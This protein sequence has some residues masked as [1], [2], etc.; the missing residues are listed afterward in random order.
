MIDFQYL[1]EILYTK[2]DSFYKKNVAE[3]GH[4][5][6]RIKFFNSFSKQE[7]IFHIIVLVVIDLS[8]LLQNF[9]NV[10]V[11]CVPNANK[12]D[13]KVRKL[14]FKYRKALLNLDFF[15]IV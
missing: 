10:K 1:S 3:V 12:I 11:A 7:Q 6:I 14:D 15:N 13:R 8:N 9:A 2:A 4:D 5:K